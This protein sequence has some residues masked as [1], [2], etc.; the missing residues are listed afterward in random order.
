MINIRKLVAVDM[1]IH[2]NRFIL[3]E[4]ALGI[5][6][7]IL[8][9]LFSVRSG[10]FSQ[11]ISVWQTTLGFWLL[12]IGI[13]YTALFFYAILISRKN[14]AKSEGQSELTHLRKNGIQQVFILVPLMVLLVS[15]IQE[16]GH[17]G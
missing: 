7:P 11:H 15:I 17:T 3:V 4:F 5:V 1:L 13:N 6:L 12:G 14:T 2:G 8:L 9:G 10:I 16:L